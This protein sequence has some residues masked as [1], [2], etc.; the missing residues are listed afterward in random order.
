MSEASSWE[1]REITAVNVSTNT[2]T[3][4]SAPSNSY[5]AGEDKVI[6]R[7]KFI[8]DDTFLIFSDTSADGMKIAEFMQAPYGLERQ[9]GMNVDKKDE[10]DPDG[11]WTRVQD[12]G[13]P[14]LYYPDTIYRLKVR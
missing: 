10:W 6:M 14:V 7:K 3:V 1:D 4:A 11:T 2:I 8:D 13:L 9:W 12:K 5:I